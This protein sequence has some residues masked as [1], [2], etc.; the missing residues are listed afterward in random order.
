[1]SVICPTITAENPHTY[2]EQMQRVSGFA[3]RIHIDLMDGVFAPSKSLGIEN[4]WLADGLINDIHVMYQK[5][6]EILSDLIA[7]QP[8]LVS[9]H[10]ESDC[11]VEEF[12]KAL[13]TAGIKCGLA[14]FPE[15]T[16]ESVAAILPH[17]DQLLIFSGNLGYQGGSVANLALLEKIPQAR[18]INPQLEFAWDGGVN[19]ENVAELASKGVTVINAGGYIHHASNPEQA[20]RKL[21]NLLT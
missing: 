19:H 9:V 8:N 16:I 11:N 2:R 13:H 20:Y 17:V 6:E 7:L 18:E 3:S 1:M 15:T 14:V 21:T 5:P 4:V 10:A 12:A